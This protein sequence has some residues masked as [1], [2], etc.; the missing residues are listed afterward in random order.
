[1]LTG[2]TLQEQQTLT[3]AWIDAQASPAMNLSFYNVGDK[4]GKERT[5]L[6]T[7]APAGQ[8]ATCRT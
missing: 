4:V 3:E 6:L 2:S 1:M 5:H 7:R 8:P